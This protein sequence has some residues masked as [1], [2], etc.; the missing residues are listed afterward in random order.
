MRRGKRS[1]KPRTH[2]NRAVVYNYMLKKYID[3]HGG[4]IAACKDINI[5]VNLF[6]ASAGDKLVYA[7]KRKATRNGNCGIA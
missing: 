6:K 5:R 3:E 2:V 4:G 1:F 7:E